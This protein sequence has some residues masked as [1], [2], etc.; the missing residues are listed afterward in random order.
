[1]KLRW[2]WCITLFSLC[3]PKLQ[4]QAVTTQ[5]PPQVGAASSL[6]EDPAQDSSLPEAHV[7]A[8]PPT[9]TPVRVQADDQ[10]VLSLTHGNEYVLTGHA[11]LYYR[12]YIIHA[13]K[14][15]YNDGTGVV[16]AQGHLMVDGG[17]DDE[18]VEADHG[19]IN[20][21]NDTAIF[22]DVVATL[23][24]RRVTR[25]RVIFTSANPYV[26][27]GREIDQLG[28]SHYRVLHG[29]MTACRLPK[30]DWRF[31]S[32]QIELNNGKAQAANA[33]FELMNTPVFYLPFVKHE[34]ANQRTSGL[35]L[36]VAG[37]NTSYGTLVGEAVYLTLGR[38]ADVLIG[39]L[40]YSKRGFAPF[41]T[42]RYK[43]E[44]DSFALVRLH[45]LLD[46]A[47]PNDPRNPLPNDGGI[48]VVGAGR[49]D[50]SP[51]TRA[52]FDGEYL[53]SYLYRLTFE[54][55]YAVAINSEV[56][57]EA[58]VLH[59]VDG[60][61]EAIRLSRYQNF[62]AVS[63]PGDE[64]RIL[65]LPQ[66]DLNSEEH[67]I[68]GTPVYWG[69][70][71]SASALSRYDYNANGPSFRTG[72]EVPRVD[73]WP[74]AD[75]PLHFGDVN[76]RPEVA[77][78]DTW[79]GKSQP[80][81]SLREFPVVENQG[82]NRFDFEGGVD[83]RPPVIGSD[84]VSHW[85]TRLFGGDLRHTIEPDVQYRFVTGINNFRQVLRFDDTDVASNT[86]E[87]Q[88]GLTQ[89]L[90]LRHLH[91]HP[92]KG[93]EALG[94]NDE[95]GGGTLD[96]LTWQIAQKHFFNP[97]FDDAIT[98][99]TPNPLLTSLDLTGV[100][101][102]TSP[103]HN[104]PII[105]RLR[106]RTVTGEDAEWDLDYD[107]KSG[108][109]TSSNVFAGYQ[110]GDIHV[111][112]GDSYLNTLIGYPPGTVAPPGTSL[113][114]PTP[115]NQINGTFVYGAESRLGFNAGATTG[116][117]LEHNQLQYGAVQAMYN[118][119]CCGLSLEY[120]RFSLA[121]VRDDTEW[122]YSFTLA[123]FG[124]TGISPGARVF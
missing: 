37:S 88:F 28:K 117:D 71:A 30:P 43:G 61:S 23:G 110:K 5:L 50:F 42:F 116:Y 66:I 20:V 9:G 45:S 22:Y 18:H 29:T 2:I 1:M 121:N 35:L 40:W 48:D 99:G 109:I 3:H 123:G 44:G 46:I 106:L 102:L 114:R 47:S 82:L 85:I 13:D 101:F 33:I 105:S 24:L 62:Q 54:Q 90:Y 51:Q 84:L 70:K 7:V 119:N 98:P 75:L 14:A 73:L 53:S 26:I 21:Y 95:C 34:I 79:Y 67:T 113:T 49:Y 124:S 122:F 81:T 108:R 93:N 100:D 76:L 32:Q 83:F 80:P 11:I 52:A 89:H 36:P 55:N 120:R 56:Q 63:P 107:A 91:P 87:L 111:R 19:T 10:Q 58:Y 72:G 77:V 69:Y 86:N 15:T 57:S 65:H 103:R 78:R 27:T 4:A 64:V 16:E 41:G 60:F 31:F 112:F 6:P 8:Q 74:H 118:W 59:D 96:W 39:S 115:Y 68:P 17:P 38:S 92:C 94:P 12:N 104:S 97:T 25:N